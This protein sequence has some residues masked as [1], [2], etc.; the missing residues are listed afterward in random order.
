MI[1]SPV[2]GWFNER[3][4]HLLSAPRMMY[5]TRDAVEGSFLLL[6]EGY[7]MALGLTKEQIGSIPEQYGDW[8]RS[9]GYKLYLSQTQPLREEDFTG[10]LREFRDVIMDKHRIGGL[11]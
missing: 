2:T 9:K 10:Q 8:L 4:E 7:L 5:G 6:L 1:I 11:E 3:I